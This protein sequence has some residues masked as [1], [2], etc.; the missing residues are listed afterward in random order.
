MWLGSRSAAATA[1]LGRVGHQ[2]KAASVRQAAAATHGPH[3]QTS[4]FACRVTPGALSSAPG[5]PTLDVAMAHARPAASSRARRC[6][7]NG[8]K[9][10]TDI[11][12]TCNT[13]A[14]VANVISYLP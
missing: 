4:R 14:A 12:E 13:A 10:C 5:C 1:L 6:W 8:S 11:I 2:A 3:V 7:G 9:S